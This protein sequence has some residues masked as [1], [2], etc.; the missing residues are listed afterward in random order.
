[1]PSCDFNP[2]ISKWYYCT[3]IKLIVFILLKK[4]MLEAA[5]TNLFNPLACGFFCTLGTNGLRAT[6]F[7]M[8]K[9]WIAREVA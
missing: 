8:K 2:L 7:G 9:Q 3:S 1:M 6:K 4:Q 5:S